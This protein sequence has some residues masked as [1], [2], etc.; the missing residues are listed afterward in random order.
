MT[1]TA[2]VATI[3]RATNDF[4]GDGTLGS[5]VAKTGRFRGQGNEE[6][7]YQIGGNNLI[8]AAVAEYDFGQDGA[9][10]IGNTGLGVF[11]PKDAIV[12]DVIIDVITTFTGPTNLGVTLENDN[13]LIDTT[14]ITLSPF[15]TGTWKGN[16]NFGGDPGA[17]PVKTTVPRE[18]CLKATVAVTSAG[19]CV[20]I[21]SY[22]MSTT[23]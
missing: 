16:D 4:N 12:D 1:L 8:H 18:I 20:I 22:H 10:A 6:P 19:K 7:K 17:S 11:I 15:I 21:V 23:A 5:G 3:L 14:A 13:D 2:K 9:L